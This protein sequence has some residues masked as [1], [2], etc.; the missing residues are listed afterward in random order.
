[1]EKKDVLLREIVARTDKGAKGDKGDS[2]P[3][4]PHGADVSV[5]VCVC[6]FVYDIHIPVF[7]HPL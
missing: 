2:G 1:M 4:G 7:D 6:R 3:Q 5:C